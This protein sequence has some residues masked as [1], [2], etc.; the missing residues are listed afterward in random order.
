MADS[1]P[2]SLRPPHVLRARA[3]EFRQMAATSRTLGIAAA[4]L[5]LA[6]RFERLAEQRDLAAGSASDHPGGEETQ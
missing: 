6:D 5:R 3:V 1:G 2:L 4:L